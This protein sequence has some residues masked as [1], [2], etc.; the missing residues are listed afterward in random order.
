M[1]PE[2][3][4]LAEAVRATLE[5]EGAGIVAPNGWRFDQLRAALAAYD[6]AK[7]PARE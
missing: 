2:S 7:E 3:D 4:R 5:W 1:T 6:A